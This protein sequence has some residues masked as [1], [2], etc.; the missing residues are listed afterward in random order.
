M[1][2]T[3]RNKMGCS[4]AHNDREFNIEKAR[5]IDI[6]RSHENVYGNIY[7]NEDLKFTD[8]EARYYKEHYSDRLDELNKSAIKNHHSNMVQS[9]TKYMS[10]HGP[11]ELL[12][13]I[14]GKDDYIDPD[15]F[16]SCVQDFLTE[17][18]KYSEHCHILDYAIHFDEKTPHAHIRKVW[19][20]TNENG[21]LDVSKDKALRALGIDV[22]YQDQPEGRFNCR[23]ITF[24]KMCRNLWADIAEEHGFII[25]KTTERQFDPTREDYAI[26]SFKNSKQEE[27]LELVRDISSVLESI[28]KEC[29]EKMEEKNNLSAQIS[30]LTIQASSLA[31][32]LNRLTSLIE[33]RKQELKKL[34]AEKELSNI[35]ELKTKSR[36][37]KILDVEPEL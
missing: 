1:K 9:M 21:N 13:Q 34:K 23:S 37:S 10:K 24:D 30:N 11:E 28:T 15:L 17:M 35:D 14:G 19:D 22:P 26:N 7:N 2:V 5:H 25:E 18:E 6:K 31:D 32:E 27:D 29:Q 4:A 8:L 36:S 3:A 33:E 12:L 20:Y 16:K